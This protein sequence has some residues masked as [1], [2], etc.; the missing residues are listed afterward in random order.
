M[1]LCPICLEVGEEACHCGRRYH[2]A[3]I[4]ELLLHGYDCC[5]SCFAVFPPSLCLSAARDAAKKQDDSPRCQIQLA[6][7]LTSAA[8]PDEAIA[9]LKNTRTQE[10]LPLLH[11]AHCIELGRAYLQL[12]RPKLASSELFSGA[13]FAQIAGSQGI[14]LHF[15]ALALLCRA[16][17]ERGDDAMTHKIARIALTQV[18]LM[19]YQ[20]ALYIMRVLADTFKRGKATVHYKSTMESICA[21]MEEESRDAVAKAAAQA[22]LGIAEHVTGIDSNARLKPAVKILRKRMHAMTLPAARSLQSQVKPSRRLHHKM[23]PEDVP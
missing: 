11:S 23:H 13:A 19:S 6:A 2:T 4:C 14:A 1:E 5:Q 9:I 8:K 10:A 15:R 22:E 20:E 16:Y 7:A 21:I 18:H 17:Y 3:C 12:G